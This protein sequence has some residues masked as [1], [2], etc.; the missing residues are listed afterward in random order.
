MNDPSK[1]EDFDVYEQDYKFI[2][3]QLNTDPHEKEFT[4][5]GT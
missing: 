2:R 3:R 1:L 5:M 4:T